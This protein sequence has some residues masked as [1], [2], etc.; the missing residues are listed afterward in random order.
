M[1]RADQGFCV[2]VSNYSNEMIQSCIAESPI[3]K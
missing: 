2:C 1:E 3:K